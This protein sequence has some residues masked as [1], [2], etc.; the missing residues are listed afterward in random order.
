MFAQSHIPDMARKRFRDDDEETTVNQGCGLAEHRNKRLYLP[1][2]SSSHTDASQWPSPPDRDTPPRCDADV[3]ME[4]DVTVIPLQSSQPGRNGFPLDPNTPRHDQ[5]SLT[6]HSPTP[7][8]PNSAAQVQDPSGWSGPG[9]TI[10]HTNGVVNMGHVPDAFQDQ[11]VPRTMH[12]Q[13]EDDWPAA[14][15][16]RIPSPISEAESRPGSANPVIWAE[17]RGNIN[18]GHQQPPPPDT[19]DAGTMAPSPYGQS[20]PAS[21]PSVSEATSSPAMSSP[22]RTRGHV[23]SLHTVNSW[24][25]QPGMKRSFSIGYRADCEKCRLKVPGHFNHIVV[26]EPAGDAMALA[27]GRPLL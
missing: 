27:D 2:R 7:V 9:P 4:M 26:S 18:P 20:S 10:S 22:G 16:H 23:R 15:H 8:Q 13:A 17:D 5:H 1:V 12:M 11:A 14:I 6:N 25:W 24:T 21:M 3:D 19:N